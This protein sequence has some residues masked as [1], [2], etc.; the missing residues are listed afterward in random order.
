MIV[1]GSGIVIQTTLATFPSLVLRVRCSIC[2]F[3]VD[4]PP[5]MKPFF[6]ISYYIYIYIYIYIDISS[7]FISKLTLETLIIIIIMNIII[8]LLIEIIMTY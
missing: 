2:L 8:K 3:F 5:L 6:A 1:D 4:S 7:E